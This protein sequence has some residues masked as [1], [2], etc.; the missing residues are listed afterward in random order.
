MKT[1]HGAIAVIVLAFSAAFPIFAETGSTWLEIGP[2]GRSSAL[3][4]AVTASP[5]NPSGGWYN[6]A[7]IGIDGGGIE[8]A[9]TDWWVD[10]TTAQHLA[11]SFQKGAFG[12]G[13]SLHSV[14]INDLELRTGP[15]ETPISLFD[16]KNYSLGGTFGYGFTKDVRLG[17]TGRYLSEDIYTYHANGWSMDAGLLWTNVV[18]GALDLG[19]S[20]RHLG[21]IE[22]LASQSYDLP[23]TV[24]AGF[25]LR[26]PVGLE[27]PPTLVVD[28]AKVRDLDP[29]VRI[30]AEAT[31]FDML[32]LRGGWRSGYEGQSLSAGFGLNWRSW[33]LDF[34][35]VPFKDD[36]GV[37][38]R[39]SLRASW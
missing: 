27:T 36:L 14:G 19:I 10:G 16:A 3:A 5:E 23:T 17:V 7:A 20:V 35:Y 11:T 24:S 6:P 33:G 31:V 28:I 32:E 13:F 1:V 38:Q 25:A 21:E 2:G 4:E 9:Y 30:G 8:L 29:S 12:Y 26:L 34:S 37:A 39:I 15:S 22:E 18:S